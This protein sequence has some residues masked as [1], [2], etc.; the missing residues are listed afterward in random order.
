MAWTAGRYDAAAV[1]A[2]VSSAT[3]TGVAYQRFLPS[4]PLAMLPLAPAGGGGGGP[5]EPPVS[6]IIWSVSPVEAAALVGAP[7]GSFLRELHAALTVASPPGVPVVTGVA[8]A[9]RASFPLGWGVAPSAVSPRVALI[10]DAAHAVH[11]LAGQGVNLGLADVATLVGVLGKAAA[12]GGDVGA[13]GRTWEAWA[14]GRARDNGRM[15]AAIEGVRRG[16]GVGGWGGR[17]A[18]RGWPRLANRGRAGRGRAVRNGVVGGWG[19]PGGGGED[20]WKGPA[21]Q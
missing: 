14:A 8:P 18:A 17:P 3:D 21:V 9:G 7:P 13:G 15:M 12:V 16:F 19:V 4:G 20:A 6:N 2:N 11:P 10:G 5:P 1:V